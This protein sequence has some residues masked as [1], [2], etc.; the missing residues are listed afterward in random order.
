MTAAARRVVLLHMFAKKS[1]KTPRRAL[2]TAKDRMQ[3]MVL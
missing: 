1:P 3:L 2:S